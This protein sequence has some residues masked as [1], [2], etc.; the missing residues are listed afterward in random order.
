MI[1]EVE[2]VILGQFIT[3]LPPSISAHMQSVV[4][5]GRKEKSTVELLEIART[6]LALRDRGDAPAAGAMR[7]QRYGNRRDLTAKSNR[8]NIQCYECKKFGHYCRECPLYITK[9]KDS[10]ICRGELETFVPPPS[11]PGM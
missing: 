7:S 5:S 6:V 11:S 4:S 10:G 3:G 1:S 8:N 9:Q 2:P